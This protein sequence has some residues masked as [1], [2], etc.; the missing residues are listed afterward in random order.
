MSL[1]FHLENVV[2]PFNLTQL[3][4]GIHSKQP[5]RSEDVAKVHLAVAGSLMINVLC[6][7]Q[8]QGVMIRIT[9]ED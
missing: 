3:S 8:K 7:K 4:V 9:H 5:S 6:S 2:A 1:V